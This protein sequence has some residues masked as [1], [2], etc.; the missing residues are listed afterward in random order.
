M[1]AWKDSENHEKIVKILKKKSENSRKTVKNLKTW[2][3]STK[4]NGNPL[5]TVEILKKVKIVRR[6]WKSSKH[7]EIPQKTVKSWKYGKYPEN[8]VKIFKKK[9]K[10]EDGN[11]EIMEKI[12]KR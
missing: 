8:M 12:I 2:W 4:D 3:I 11:P 9:G 6:G 1:K 7:S 10:N 5:E